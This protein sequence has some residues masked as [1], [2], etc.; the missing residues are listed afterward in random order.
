MMGG[1]L[2][3]NEQ[4]AVVLTTVVISYIFCMAKENKL[5]PRGAWQ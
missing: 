1:G 2:A 5:T 3:V 4:Q